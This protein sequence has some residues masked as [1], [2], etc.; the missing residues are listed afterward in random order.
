MRR[1]PRRYPRILLRLIYLL[2]AVFR[3]VLRGRQLYRRGLRRGRLRVRRV[4]VPIEGLAPALDGMRIAHVSDFHAGPFLRAEDLGELVEVV[5]ESEPDLVCLTGDFITHRVEE[6]L[7]LVEAFREFRPTT[8]SYCVFGN[9]DYRA[10]R[11]GEMVDAFAAIGI[12]AL[13]NEGVAIERGGGRLWLAGIEDVEEGKVVDLDAALSG[14]RDGDAV[15]LLAHHPDC[16][17]DVEGCDVDLVLSGHTHGGQIVLF[18]RSIF[19]G[20]LRSRYR[21]GLYRVGESWLNVTSGIGVLIVPL[22][23]GAPPEVVLLTLSA[24]S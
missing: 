13:R 6:G 24:V 21:V 11:E 23:I 16:A 3:T 7:S 15:V 8:G 10:R 19:G 5:N 17:E 18:G 12:H 22:R 14:R 1:A 4:D 20:S 2:E 9:H